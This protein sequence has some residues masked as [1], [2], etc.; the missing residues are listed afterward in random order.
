MVGYPRLHGISHPRGVWVHGSTDKERQ[1]A[2]RALAHMGIEARVDDRAEDVP[3]QIIVGYGEHERRPATQDQPTRVSDIRQQV[4]WST[5]KSSF[6]S[7][8]ATGG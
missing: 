6:S 3:L 8:P 2:I 1:F 5:D 7:V 4:E